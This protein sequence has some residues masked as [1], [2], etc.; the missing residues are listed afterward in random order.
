MYFDTSYLAKFYFNEPESSAV[1]QLVHTAD[2]IH[3]SVWALAELHA[4]I[5]RRARELS[6]SP[7]DAKEL[8]ARFYEHL[9]AGLWKLL[10]VHEAL[11]K[12]TSAL[13]VSAPA[14]LFIRTADA[15]HLMTAREAGE[16]E[17]W[18]NDRHMLTAA[19]YFGVTGR[20][21]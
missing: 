21:I 3:S 8:S 7:D 13:M 11:L 15:V 10:P 4:V 2:I 5:H 14:D 1:R 20:S 16:R 18:T 17:V 6:I 19:A 12:R 9:E